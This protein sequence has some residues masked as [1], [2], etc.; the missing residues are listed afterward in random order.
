MRSRSFAP[1]LVSS[2]PFL[3]KL[4]LMLRSVTLSGAVTD[5]LVAAELLDGLGSFW[6]AIALAMLL[7]VPAVVGL[8]TM[9]TVA[10]VLVA[11]APRLHVTVV[12]PVQLPWLELAETKLTAAG[13]ASVMVTPV[14]TEGPLLVTVTV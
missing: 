5:V 7:I 6:A 13:R 1:S 3:R 4:S 14:A 9:V 2:A 10:L 12:V 11:T 8:P